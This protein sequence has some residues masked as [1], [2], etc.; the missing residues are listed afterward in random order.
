MAQ[1][2]GKVAI[3]TG[4]SKGIGAAIAK[5]LG[6]AGAKVVVNYLADR[7]GAERVA[8]A[9][10]DAGGEATTFGADVSKPADVQQLFETTAQVFGRPDILI[11]N[12]GLYRFEPFEVVTEAEF[13]R[14][15]DTN[16]L[17]PV[18]TMQE[19]VK[20][21]GT[22]GGVIVNIATAGVSNAGPMS[23]T[24]TSSKAALVA[25]SRVLANELGPRGIRV[26][27]VCPGA[28]ETEGAHAIGVLDGDMVKHLVATTP[29]GRLGQPE[30]LVG[31]VLFLASD[32]AK[33]VTGEVLFASGGSR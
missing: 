13:R 16:V 7:A 18:L 32:A 26:N 28:T 29:L 11:N 23:S 22:T 31:P 20:Q 3:V 12:A 24:Y 33:W 5:G 6:L 10:A 21:F 14:I 4:A 25:L 8:S 9:I 2:T 19:A 27:V 15:Y 30:D 1:L 17:G